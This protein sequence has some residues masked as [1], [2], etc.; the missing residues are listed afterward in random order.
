MSAEDVVTFY[1]CPECRKVARLPAGGV[2]EFA[3]NFYSTDWL[4]T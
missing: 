1:V 2:K 4:M 3:T